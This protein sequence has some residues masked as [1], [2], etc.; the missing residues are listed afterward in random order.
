MLD[1]REAA[2]RAAVAGR[3]VGIDEHEERVAVAVRADV[4]EVQPVAARL[5]LGPE[6]A[7]GAGPERDLLRLEGLFKRLGVH[8]AEHEHPARAG[9]LHDG[10]NQS[11]GLLPVERLDVFVGQHVLTSMLF[12]RR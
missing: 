4:D 1:G 9:V 3:A 7:L 2:R 5:A 12:S 10:R 8:A 6:A 11:A